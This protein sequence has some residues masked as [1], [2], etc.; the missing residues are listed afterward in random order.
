MPHTRSVV[1]LVISTSLHCFEFLGGLPGLKILYR[2][3]LGI[4]MYFD[5]YEL[6]AFL[7]FFL[8]YIPTFSCRSAHYSGLRYTK[9]CL[10]GFV[11]AHPVHQKSNRFH[12]RKSHIQFPF[13]SVLHPPALPPRDQNT[14]PR[15]YLK[16]RLSLNN[17]QCLKSTPMR[18]NHSYHS[19]IE[20]SRKH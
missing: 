18:L 12:S 2:R 3:P 8:E 13:P 7:V 1:V 16:P 4:A 19:Q 10:S 15:L 6:G 20:T 5:N 9:C 11:L 17:L 14:L